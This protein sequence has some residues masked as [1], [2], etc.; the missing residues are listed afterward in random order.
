M[1]SST[2]KFAYSKLPHHAVCYVKW[3]L[4]SSVVNINHKDYHGASLLFLELHIQGQI[5]NR[6]GDKKVFFFNSNLLFH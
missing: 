1:C 5:L 4:Y 3:K 6:A 2:Y